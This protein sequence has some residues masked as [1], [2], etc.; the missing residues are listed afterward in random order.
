MSSEQVCFQANQSQLSK[1]NPRSTCKQK[2]VS[3]ILHSLGGAGISE[4]EGFSHNPRP[5]RVDD[6]KFNITPLYSTKVKAQSLGKA[7]E[8]KAEFA[9]HWS[10]EVPLNH[11]Y[12]LPSPHHLSLFLFGVYNISSEGEFRSGVMTVPYAGLE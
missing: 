7:G 8:E 4:S 5:I 3:R 6:A 10:L 2:H 12:Q 11:P 9:S 1:H